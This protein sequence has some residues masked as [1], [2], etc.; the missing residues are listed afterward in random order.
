MNRFKSILE[1]RDLLV[2]VGCNPHLIVR[3]DFKTFPDYVCDSRAFRD[4]RNSV[5]SDCNECVFR[6]TRYNEENLEELG[7]LYDRLREVDAKETN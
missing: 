5:T 7:E 1:L 3:D 6:S 4:V 2:T